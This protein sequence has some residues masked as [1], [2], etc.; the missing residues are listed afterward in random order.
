M[1]LLLSLLVPT[2]FSFAIGTLR[3]TP[4][5]LVLLAAFVPSLVRL[6]SG[7]AGPVSVIDLLLFAH[8]AWAYVVFGYHHGSG[9]AI[10]SGGIRMIEF[11]GAYLIARTS[12]LNERAFR[13]VGVLIFAIVCV[14][15]PLTLLE[16]VSGIH[17][18]KLLAAKLTG[19]H[20]IS[21]IEDRFGL[22]RAFGPFDHPI[23][24]GLFVASA[25]G[26][27]SIRALPRLGSPRERKLP[28]IA[29]VIAAMT[30][31]SSGAL[32]ALMVQFTLLV[33]DNKTRH[34]RSRWK[35]F[36]ALLLTAY[37]TVDLISNRSGM[38]VFLHYLTFSAS[39]AYNRIII[40]DYG[41]LDVW[42]NP[43]FGIGFNVWTKPEWMHST[44]MDNFWL[45][46]A[47]TFG[48]PGFVT[49]A[50]AVILMLSLNWDSLPDRIKRL[51]TGWAISMIGVIV[52][53]CTVHLWNSVFVYFAFLL[54]MGAWFI[55]VRGR[56]EDATYSAA[57]GQYEY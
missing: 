5:R 40:F 43:T 7:R 55:N 32:A 57:G 11:G 36:T 50:M 25:L 14:L 1:I 13:G 48:I 9:T 2:E 33:W 30:S 35:L 45:V 26:M 44:S 12:I 4:Y 39:T 52:A 51:R 54:G 47:V 29:V 53:A 23:L 20:F 49:I 16:S 41:I 15:A 21:G 8:L 31:V 46:Q 18:I 37:I 42:R 56:R 27:V 34:I 3:L 17:F 24:F 10:E 38:K 22:S 6:L 19:G 28:R